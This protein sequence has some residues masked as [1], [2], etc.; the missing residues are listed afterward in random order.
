MKETT[1][2]NIG[3][4]YDLTANHHLLFSVGRGLQNVE[5]T[6]KLSAYLAYQFTF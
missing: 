4:A 1:G 3:G 5:E 2:F 6:N